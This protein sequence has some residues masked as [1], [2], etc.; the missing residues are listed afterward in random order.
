MPLE[1]VPASMIGR[2]QIGRKTLHY[3]YIVMCTMMIQLVTTLELRYIYN[4]CLDMQY[5]FY[6]TK[7]GNIKKKLARKSCGNAPPLT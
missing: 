3:V 2:L 6:L 1:Q 7:K 5:I 4:I